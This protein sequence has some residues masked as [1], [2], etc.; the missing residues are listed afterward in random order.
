MP[1]L[2]LLDTLGL[3]PCFF[4]NLLQYLETVRVTQVSA[5]CLKKIIRSGTS[6]PTFLCVSYL[7][8]LGSGCS[9]LHT[10]ATWPLVL[11]YIIL[12]ALLFALSAGARAGPK[13]S[14]FFTVAHD[15]GHKQ[16]RGGWRQ[17]K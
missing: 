3:G 9:H 16:R 10:F 8:G 13:Q 15:A 17:L 6:G 5:F 1:N 7:A 12:Y 14:A 4:K 11:I 2:A